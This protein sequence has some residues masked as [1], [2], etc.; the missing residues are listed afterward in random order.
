MCDPECPQFTGLTYSDRGSIILLV[1][2]IIF[3]IRVGRWK[4]YVETYQATPVH[5]LSIG[6]VF[7][8][9]LVNLWEIP[10]WQR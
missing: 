1:I 10:F 2:L 7:K 3:I 9:A 6:A 4:L 5:F 8:C